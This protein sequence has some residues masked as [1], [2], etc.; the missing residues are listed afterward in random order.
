MAN[1]GSKA[2]AGALQIRRCAAVCRLSPTRFSTILVRIAA[3]AASTPAQVKEGRV[4]L[5]AATHPRG[6]SYIFSSAAS[7]EALSRDQLQPQRT[8]WRR[9]ATSALLRVPDP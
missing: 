7:L 8:V 9:Q 5:C 3:M 1:T 6:W 2:D 4:D